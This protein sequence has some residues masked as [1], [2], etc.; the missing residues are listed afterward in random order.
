MK[1]L[2]AIATLGLSTLTFADGF[3]CQTL[4]KDLS[5]KVYNQTH[6]SA[7]TKNAAVMV[8]S[9]NKVS[10]GRKTIAKFNA[11][12]TLTNQGAAYVAKVDLRFTDSS[13]KGENIGGTKLGYIKT[14]SLDVDFNYGAPLQKGETTPAVLRINKRN[15]DLIVLDAD[16]SRY[17]KN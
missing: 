13:R 15:G 12:K 16:C 11:P 7:G 17:L 5:I 14:I 8:I 1:N 2:I 3:V 9:D 10:F 6:A 4:E